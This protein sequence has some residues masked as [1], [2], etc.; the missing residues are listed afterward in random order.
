V[1]PKGEHSF[2]GGRRSPERAQ[3]VEGRDA[4]GQPS[5]NTTTIDRDVDGNPSSISGPYGQTT[6]LTVDPNGYVDS[7]TDPVGQ[8]FSATFDQDGL[9]QTVTDARDHT[10]Y[11]EYDQYGRI[12]SGIDRGGVTHTM[13]PSD[14]FTEIS[15]DTDPG[16]GHTTNYTV[17]NTQDGAVHKLNTFPN[18]TSAESVQFQSGLEQITLPSGMITTT[19]SNPDPRFGLQDPLTVTTQQTP[20]GLLRTETNARTATLSNANDPLG[21]TSQTTTRTINGKTWTSAYN[22]SLR[23]LIDTSPVGRTTTQFFDANNNLTQIQRPGITTINFTYD[24]NGRL[25]TITQ[26]ARV[27]TNTYFGSGATKGYLATIQNALNQ[28]TSFTADAVGRTLTQTEPDG[29]VIGFGYDANSNLT[30]VTPPGKPEHIQTYT[31]T[32]ELESYEPPVLDDVPNP[33]TTYTYNAERKLTGTIRPDGVSLTRSY[34]SAGRLSLI[35]MPTGTILHEYY[36]N[37]VCVGCAPGSLKRLTGPGTSIIDLT[38]DGSLLRSTTWSGAVSGSVAWTHDNDFRTATETVTPGGSTITYAY[39]N[40]NL[41]TCAS[42]ASCSPP[43]STALRLTYNSTNGLLTSTVIG[44]LTETFTYNALG[45]LATH[46]ATYSGSPVYSGT[47]HSTAAPRDNLGRITRKVETVAGVTR[48]DDYQYDTR[49]RLLNVARNN[50]LVSIYDYDDNGNRL[51]LTNPSTSSVTLGSYDDQDRVTNYGSFEYTFNANGDLTSKLNTATNEETTY[52]Y[53]AR[54]ALISV[55]LPDST[56]IEYVIDGQGRRVGKKVNGTLVQGFIYKDRLRIAA[57]LDGSG[58]VVAQFIYAGMSHSPDFMINDG[59]VY[60]FVKDQLGSPR[61]VVNVTT[62]AIAQQLEYD[63]FGHLLA[64]S[65]TGF[66]PFGFAGGLYDR[67]TG[68]VRF[69]A[70]DYDASTGRW[71]A[72]DPISFEGGDTDLFAYASNDPVNAIDPN[73]QAT[74]IGAV[75]LL[76]CAAWD[77]WD[78]YQSMSGLDDLRRE[79]DALQRLLRVLEKLPCQDEDNFLRILAIRQEILS[80]EAA[81]ARSQS[82]GLA[83]AALT[84]LACVIIGTVF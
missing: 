37:T 29:A 25:S 38:Y 50:T 65:A 67:D 71:T 57:E 1:Q 21:L 53:D 68:L 14:D 30:S 24:A 84:G 69:G 73:G 31:A 22:A 46:N 80:K 15:V 51:S 76:V 35:T 42:P 10:A 2:G 23:R 64:D 12:I 58:N 39:D 40:D 79:I 18:G 52:E 7:I 75:G 47:F 44:N 13:T 70:R 5:G 41:V 32:N 77:V 19:Q 17:F 56:L 49:G 36:D 83:T 82:N 55:V 81:Y 8:T 61:V 9:I 74:I 45:E 28:T 16:G 60:R 63:E 26:G 43:A 66:Q 6:L 27:T 11:L 62:G 54:G 59:A 34:D 20:S 72:K 78:T 33:E 4:W 48:T 3:R